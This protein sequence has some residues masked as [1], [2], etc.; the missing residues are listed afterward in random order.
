MAHLEL[1]FVCDTENEDRGTQGCVKVAAKMP[2]RSM[3]AMA[4]QD[5]RGD[6]SS[7]GVE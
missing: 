2:G 7:S 4:G 1:E 5:R 6:A 3:H